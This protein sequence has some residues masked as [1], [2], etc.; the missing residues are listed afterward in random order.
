VSTKY[1]RCSSVEDLHW[2]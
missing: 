1:K 2:L